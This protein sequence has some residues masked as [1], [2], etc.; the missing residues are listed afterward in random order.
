M[1]IDPGWENPTIEYLGRHVFS[2]GL[3]ARDDWG[4]T[5]GY[6]SLMYAD[7]SGRRWTFVLEPRP[8]DDHESRKLYMTVNL[9]ISSSDLPGLESITSA[10]N[11]SLDRS[12]YVVDQLMRASI[13]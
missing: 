3:F 13:Q 2:A 1:E 9:H 11:E 8:R 10:L 4:Q 5:G 12:V 7:P 6:G